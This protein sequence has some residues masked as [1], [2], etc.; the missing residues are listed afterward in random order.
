ER[1]FL[2]IYEQN[3][4]VGGH[5]NTVT[6]R[7]G[8]RDV[9]IDTGFMVFNHATYPN[10]CRLFRELAVET[11]K[12]DMSF[13]VQHLPTNLEYNGGSLNLLF[14][15]RR[16]ILR[17]R[18]WRMLMAINRFNQEAVPA[19]DDPRFADLTLREY[20]DARGY[21]DDMFNL[22]LAPM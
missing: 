15:Q 18:H 17:P 16:N 12:T 10:L 14:G 6:V 20:V 9:A 4:Y 19:L 5:T 21:G 13:S 22:Y 3:R 11:K 8:D 1:F 7:E 2:T